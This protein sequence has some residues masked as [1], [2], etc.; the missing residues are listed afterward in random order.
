MSNPKQ[1]RLYRITRNALAVAISAGL[2][3]AVQAQDQSDETQGALEEVIVTAS[4]REASV[5][6]LSMSVTAL[7]ME[8]L[9]KAEITD[10]SRLDTMVPGLQFASSGNE[11]RLALRGTRQNNVGTEGEQAV[12]IFEDGVYVPTSTQA[13]GSYLDINRIEVL[14]GPQGTLYGRNTFGG[15]I[16]IITND[17]E[18]EEFYGN[19]MA[20]YGDYNRIK[21]EGVVNIP[22][23]ESFA[24]RLA[25]LSDNHDGYIINTWIPGTSDDLNDR[26]DTV[27]RVG[28]KWFATDNFTAKLKVTYN[29]RK[30]NGSAIWGYQQ[31][32]GY[33][34]GEFLPGNQIPVTPAATENSDE[35]PWRIARNQKSNAD[36]EN[37][38]YT[39]N[40][41]WDFPDFAT[42]KFIGNITELDGEQN[43]DPDYS[44]GGDAENAGFTGWL[45]TQD[46]WSTELQLVSNTDGRVDWMAGLY[47]YDQTATWNWL[48]LEDGVFS[49]PHWDNQ[50]DY[51]SDSFGAF[52]NATFR[53][54]DRT[55][56][57]GGLRYAEDSKKQRDLLD[58]NVWPPVAIPNSG[59]E[60]EWD[61]WLW[62]AGIEFDL[63]DDMMTYFTVSTGYRAG[64]INVA[65]EGVPLTYDP[66]EVLA[67]EVGLKSVLLDGGMT[68]NIAA[69]YNDFTDMQAQ[70]FK[71]QD[72][73][74]LE[75]T[76][77]GGA[78][79]VTG[80]EV[81]MNW[82]PR[83]DSN[84]NVGAQ[85]SIMD[86]EFGDYTIG[87]IFGV[88][89]LG[90]RQ[91]LDNPDEPLL[92]LKGMSPAMSPKFT[93]GSQ[94]SY[95]WAL[96]NDSVI[97]PYVQVYYTDDYYGFDL[98]MPGNNQDSYAR[99]DLR[100]MWDSPSGAIHL[101]AFVLNATDEEVFNRA[102]IFN[103]S[104]NPLLG[105][106]QTNW[107][108]PRTWGVAMRYNF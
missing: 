81:E 85:L 70:S 32:G 22:L 96:D 53:V 94:V 88:G 15:T 50:G 31:I 103:P 28:A 95:N 68:L 64:G 6:D 91:D 18:T 69:Y 49:V 27:I 39:L 9:E 59:L 83:G 14:R 93:L 62:K 51:L 24:L 56:L 52:G 57:I 92:Q 72:V 5:Q 60:G 82:V 74:V 21:L 67:Y 42:L 40:L 35:G 102:L 34:D 16:N 33:I 19:V 20:L 106:I 107:N 90:G 8:A 41:D 48:D 71:A 17:P 36:I 76:E 30:S 10:I 77:N 43:Y 78:V 46:T 79:D 75:F 66:E 12:G 38:V 108:N 99:W 84:W 63:N 26:D 105:S 100:L 98:N 13:M 44:D 37:S 61:K 45:S 25:A 89:D 80:M 73:G 4:K 11:V 87:K 97:T 86:A 23:S 29:D 1:Q 58:W 54:S 2:A 7:T 3:T 101:N 47:F 65:I 55:R 104:S